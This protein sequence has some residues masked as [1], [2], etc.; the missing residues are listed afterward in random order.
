MRLTLQ[1]ILIDAK[2]TSELWDTAVEE[3]QKRH[4]W[5]EGYNA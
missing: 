4:F 3:K 2:A 1:E 5:T